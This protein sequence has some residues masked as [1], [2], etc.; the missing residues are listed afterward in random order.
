MSGA[1]PSSKKKRNKGRNPPGPD[2]AI[3]G[4]KEEEFQNLVRDMGFLPEWGAQFPNPNSTALDAPPGYITLYAAFFREGNFRLPMMKFTAA[5]LTNYGLHI[6][7][8]NALGLPRVTHFEFICRACRIEPTFEMFNW[9]LLSKHGTKKLTE[10]ATSI[11]QLEEMAL[12][13]AGMS[14]LWVPKNPFGVPVYGYQGKLGYSLLNVLDPKAGGAMVE[15][16]QKD[17][18]STWLD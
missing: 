13:G 16:I 17:G 9:V 11:S 8:I 15:A 2:Q 4:W 18:K 5:I 10:K 1:N 12:V 3:I 6:S 14:L 7:Q